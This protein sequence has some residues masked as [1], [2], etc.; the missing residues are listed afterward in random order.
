MFVINLGGK[1]PIY[2]QLCAEI[3]RQ[4]SVGILSPHEKLPAVREVA[5]E[6]G[7]NPNTV[8]KTYAILE[9]TGVIYSVPAKG[10]YVAENKDAMK[11]IHE[12]NLKKCSIA[13]ENA[14]KSGIGKA[15]VLKLIEEIF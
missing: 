2:E 1:L 4:I 13:L 8:Q 3:K 14:M 11:A 5:K 9:Q 10:S 7:I 15:E 6:L 12:E